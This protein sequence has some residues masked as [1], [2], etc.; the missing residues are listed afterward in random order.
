MLYV[1]RRKIRVMPASSRSKKQLL[2][3]TLPSLVPVMV[4]AVVS[5]IQIPNLSSL[6]RTS[7]RRSLKNRSQTKKSRELTPYA[8]N[9]IQ[10]RNHWRV[11]PRRRKTTS[12]QLRNLSSPAI[13]SSLRLIRNQIQLQ[14]H[15]RTWQTRIKSMT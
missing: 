3:L 2:A 4:P 8:R 5:L 1:L 13:R 12:G 9:I 7:K 6:R 15:S 11:Q 10:P 14:I